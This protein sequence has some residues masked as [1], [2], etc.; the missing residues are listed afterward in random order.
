MQAGG[1]EGRG[2]ERKGKGR[3]GGSLIIK[4]GTDWKTG[5]VWLDLV[6]RRLEDGYI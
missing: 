6:K 5:G 3:E 4:T 2:K 1:R